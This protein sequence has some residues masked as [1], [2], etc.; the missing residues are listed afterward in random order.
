MMAKAVLNQYMK[1]VVLG[2]IALGLMT[3]GAHAAPQVV[4]ITDS[5]EDAAT[6]GTS[7]YSGYQNNSVGPGG[8]PIFADTSINGQN[9]GDTLESASQP[10]NTSQIQITRDNSAKT[11]TF[12]MTTEYSGSDPQAP[13]GLAKY[14]DLFIDT[15]T[16]N[17]P[18]TFNYAISLGQQTGGLAAGVYTNGSDKTSQD[19]WKTQTGFAYGGDAARASDLAAYQT[20]EAAYTTY[21]SALATYNTAEAAYHTAYTAY[22]TAL[23]AYNT[24]LATYNT[25]EAAYLAAQARYPHT[26]S[27]WPARPTAPTA[28]TAPTQPTAP[29][30]VAQP[31]PLPE[32]I[33]PVRLTSGTQLT[34]FSVVESSTLIGGVY[35]S[36]ADRG[37][38]IVKDVDGDCTY[39][40]KVTITAASA[41][42]LNLFNSFDVF[43][44]TA[45]CSNDAIW[46]TV[47][48]HAPEPAS[49]LLLVCGLLGLLGL[50]RRRWST[51]GTV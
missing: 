29:T 49:I 6:K 3:I 24:A 48:T 33:P 19:L 40:V 18:D 13:A 43:W 45:D 30:V 34:D 12:D 31:A 38:C 23:T 35:T 9:W 17:T 37:Q 46:G 5:V 15:N 50:N 7:A 11:I 47:A 26:P 1:R 25:K 32:I 21:L 44:G 10:F 36:G 14:A 22:Q 41:A 27:R 16:P 8:G 28:P 4:T 51:L 2:G 20:A 39:D 42:D